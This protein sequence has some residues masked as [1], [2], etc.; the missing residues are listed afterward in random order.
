VSAFRLAVIAGV[1][2]SVLAAGASPAAFSETKSPLVGTW[3]TNVISQADAEVT[4]RRHGL[5]KWIAPFRHQTPFAEPMSL[6][7]VIT[8]KSWDLYGKPTGKPR[9]EIDYDARYVVKGSTVDKIH[10]S[11]FTTLRWS[12]KGSKLTFRWVKTTEPAFMG[13][14][15]KVFQYALYQT[16]NFSRV[17]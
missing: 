9:V 1:M 17:R 10:S 6:I 7:L 14:P 12:V 3:R 4:L 2:A 15:D 5:S 11:G 13:I 8:P 16:R